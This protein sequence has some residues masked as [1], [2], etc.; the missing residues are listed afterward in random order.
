MAG[1][2]QARLSHDENIGQ[3]VCPSSLAGFTADFI[4][5]N[6]NHDRR[7]AQRLEWRAIV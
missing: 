5:A 3:P 1:S 7:Q 4:V 2:H 6:F